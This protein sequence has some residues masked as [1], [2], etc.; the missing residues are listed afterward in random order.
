MLD[1]RSLALSAP[2]ENCWSRIGITGDRTCPE[3]EEAIHCR[4]CPVYSTAARRLLERA[5]PEA[6]TQ[7]WCSLAVSATETRLTGAIPVV[8]F[9]IQTEWMALPARSFKEITPPSVIHSLPHR[10]DPILKGLVSIRGEIL[11]CISMSRLLDLET[12]PVKAPSE[13][14]A[15]PRMA[16]LEKGADRWVFCVDEV[17][18]IHRL[19][20]NDMTNVPVTVTK[21]PHPYV[22]ALFAREGETTAFLDEEALFG[23]VHRKLLS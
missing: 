9:R 13:R 11:M 1:E 7:D 21:A 22:Q 16:V 3:L 6:Y 18:G 12:D 10:R 5:A 20:P 15:Y 19:H 23:V 14:V 17:D 2:I 8:V 4:N